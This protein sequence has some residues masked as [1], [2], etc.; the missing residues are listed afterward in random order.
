MTNVK[1]KN[2][3]IAEMI[4]QPIYIPQTIY[5]SIGI[6]T[7]LCKTRE[8]AEELLEFLKPTTKLKLTIE[9]KNVPF[10]CDWNWLMKAVQWISDKGYKIDIQLPTNIILIN[11]EDKPLEDEIVDIQGK[12]L[13]STVF[14]GVYDFSQYLKSLI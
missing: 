3:A 10:D 2:I 9:V 6:K 4:G 14:R 7:N 13:L 11:E 8:E 5:G 1:K 12:D